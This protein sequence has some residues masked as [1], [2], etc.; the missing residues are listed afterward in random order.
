[1]D[2]AIY[3][4]NKNDLTAC[5]VG[6]FHEFE[7]VAII[8]DPIQHL[9]YLETIG[10][11][12][13]RSKVFDSEILSV[14][15]SSLDKLLNFCRISDPAVGPYIEVWSLGQQITDNIEK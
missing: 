15:F 4:I 8:Y 7:H 11:T 12:V 5:W 3:T 14:K 13:E 1:M 9:D 10:I 6:T 2:E